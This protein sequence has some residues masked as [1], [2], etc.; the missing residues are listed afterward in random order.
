MLYMDSIERLQKRESNK[1]PKFVKSEP[2][3]WL[4]NIVILDRKVREK[5][6]IQTCPKLYA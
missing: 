6:W 3:Y 4:L 1:K 2:K 5:G